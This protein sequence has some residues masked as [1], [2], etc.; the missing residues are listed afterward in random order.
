MFFDIPNPTSSQIQPLE[1]LHGTL[2]A[3]AVTGRIKV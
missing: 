3:Y 2:V 1:T